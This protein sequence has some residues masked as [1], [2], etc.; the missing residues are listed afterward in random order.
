MNRAGKIWAGFGIAFACLAAIF[1][2]GF[3]AFLKK[4]KENVGLNTTLNVSRYTIY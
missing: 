4:D 3:V 1:A 2:A